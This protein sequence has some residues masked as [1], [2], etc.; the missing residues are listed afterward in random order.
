VSAHI[1]MTTDNIKTPQKQTNALL[2]KDFSC[3]FAALIEALRVSVCVRVRVIVSVIV[4][5]G[6][7][8]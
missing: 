7:G 3:A 8:E 2:G 5:H 4:C 6:S 1:A